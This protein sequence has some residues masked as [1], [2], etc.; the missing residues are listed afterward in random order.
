[1]TTRLPHRNAIP[2]ILAI[3]LL[4]WSSATTQAQTRSSPP[5]DATKT[6]FH[7]FQ[8]AG[9]GV[10]IAVLPVRLLNRPDANVGH[11]LGLLLEKNGLH[12]VQPAPAAFKPADDATWEDLPAR[13]AEHLRQ[14][15]PPTAYA[16]YAEIIGTHDTGV[17]ELR[18]IVAEAG[19]QRVL[20]ERLMK[21]SPE[22]KQLLGSNPEPMTCCV[23]VT[24]RLFALTGWKKGAAP[25]KGQGTFE[26]LWAEKSG[27]PDEAETK[28]MAERLAKFK[29]NL[30]GATLAIAPTRLNDKDDAASAGRLAAALA[31]QFG[32]KAIALDA[33]IRLD[34]AGSSNEQ[35]VL[36]D[37]AKGLRAHLRGNPPQADYVLMAD[38][39]GNPQGTDFGAVHV[40]VCDKEGN[41]VLVDY[42]NN[43]HADFNKINPK[44]IEDC[45][46]LVAT[47]LAARLR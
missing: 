34:L 31:A 27:T 23:A 36:W 13:L 37:F 43:H 42:Q 15:P 24:E 41:W 29:A 4:P 1:M 38:C 28:A 39:R 30:R 32:C 40:V 9:P 22:L 33:A 2:V 11:A 46:K 6:A 10:G 18:W 26:R 16:L 5:D 44:R 21:G 17:V 3:T 47:R 8:Q 25:A 19:G 35:R 12:H 20:S 14:N 45:E 7:K